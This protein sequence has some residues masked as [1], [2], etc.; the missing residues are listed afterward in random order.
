MR[1]QILA[2]LVAFAA[3][4]A[5]LLAQSTVYSAANGVVLLT[6]KPGCYYT[7]DIAGRSVRPA[8]M[9]SSPNPLFSADGKFLQVIT[10]S[11]DE[12]RTKPNMSDEDFLR[13]HLS[14]EAEHHKLAVADIKVEVTTLAKGQTALFWSFLP[15]FPNQRSRYSLRFVPKVM[16]SSLA[17]QLTHPKPERRFAHSSSRPPTASTVLRRQSLCSLPVTVPTRANPNERSAELCAT[18]NG[19][20]CC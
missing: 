16:P 1:I 6:N 9:D 7:L 12:F 14:Y 2:S 11:G 8:G 3:L 15:P 10:V 4:P 20:G 13:S 17:Q 18:S 5:T 19:F